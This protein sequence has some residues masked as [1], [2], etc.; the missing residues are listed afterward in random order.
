MFGFGGGA[1][2]RPLGLAPAAWR[3]AVLCLWSVVWDLKLRA[4]TI[5]SAALDM[6]LEEPAAT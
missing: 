6:A 5:G 2:A 3:G 4:H 1:P